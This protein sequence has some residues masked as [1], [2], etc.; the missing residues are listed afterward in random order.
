MAQKKFLVDAI[1]FDLDGT[2]IDSTPGV[3]KAWATFAKDYNLNAEE[4]AHATHGRRLYDTLKEF[5]KIQDE[6][7]LKAEI[8]RFEQEVIEGGPAVLPG[9]QDLLKT[10]ALEMGDRWTIV[11]S[12]SRVYAPAAIAKC[13]IPVPQLGYITSD[14]VQHGK[15]HP[16]PYLAGADKC[17]IDTKS[18]KCLVV[19]DAPSGLLSGHAA[20]A[21]TLAVCTS[22]SR[23]SIQKSGAAPDYIVKDLTRVA[24]RWLS[25]SEMIEVSVDE[26]E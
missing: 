23:E 8:V 14:D 26:T 15:P 3:F 13:D 22:H 20:D 11:T 6:T 5:C 2:L 9:A 21:I 1:L 16:A 10:L 19:E 18:K 7:T 12:S 17:G 25:D 4:V 24:V